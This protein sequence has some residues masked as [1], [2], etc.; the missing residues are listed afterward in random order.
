MIIL[1]KNY[2]II[3]L[4]L[5]SQPVSYSYGYGYHQTPESFEKSYQITFTEEALSRLNRNPELIKYLPK[6]PTD[7]NISH[8]FFKKR[9]DCIP[10]N[11]IEYRFKSIKLFSYK[12]QGQLDK[13]A[14]IIVFPLFETKIKLNLLKKSAK[15]LS[16][17]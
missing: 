11:L 17:F 6:Q 14:S 8:A 7:K 3:Q 12:K 2:R 4:N 5:S 13:K 1:T 15:Y 16:E 10:L 9:L